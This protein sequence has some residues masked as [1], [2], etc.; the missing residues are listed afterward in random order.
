MYD[1]SVCVVLTGYHTQGLLSTPNCENYADIVSSEIGA[2]P[3]AG[4]PNRSRAAL[5]SRF[6]WCPPVWSVVPSGVLLPPA[7]RKFGGKVRRRTAGRKVRGP[8]PPGLLGSPSAVC[9]AGSC[10][11]G[12]G[13]L[14]N[15]APPQ[16]ITDKRQSRLR[17]GPPE[18]DETGGR[19]FIFDIGQR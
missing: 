8:C 17:R 10:A 9:R 16:A 13:V 5:Y 2:D 19:L 1:T 4:A 3:E 18:A 12:R 7:V 15:K 11:C 6:Q 14:S